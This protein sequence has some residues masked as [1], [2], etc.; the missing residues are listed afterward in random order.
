MDQKSPVQPSHPGRGRRPVQLAV[1][2][3]GYLAVSCQRDVRLQGLGASRDLRLRPGIPQRG[4]ASRHPRRQRGRVDERCGA[5][6]PQH[7]QWSADHSR[8]H[9]PR[10]RMQ[11]VEDGAADLVALVGTSSRTRT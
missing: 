3:S 4:R 2:P 10:W 1:E 6:L 8:R 5:P 7:L 11:I 9:R